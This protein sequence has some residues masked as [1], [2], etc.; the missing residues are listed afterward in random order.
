MKHLSNMRHTCS[1]RSG[2]SSTKTSS[3]KY[4]VERSRQVVGKV[5]KE[6]IGTTS[7]K[8]SSSGGSVSACIAGTKIH[9]ETFFI[10]FPNKFQQMVEDLLVDQLLVG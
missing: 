4:M 7:A 10:E 8:P 6:C 2:T 3:V 9:G 1:G 5:T